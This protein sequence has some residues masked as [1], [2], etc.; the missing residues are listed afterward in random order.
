MM[1]E[2]SGDLVVVG[3]IRR[4]HGVKGV[5]VVEPT[6][7]SAHLVFV[8]G[9]EFI[10]GTIK[11]EP[12][13]PEKHLRVEMAEPF[14]GGYRVQLDA[15]T[16]R[17]EADRW[18]KRCLL[19]PRAGLPEPGE[20]EIYLHDLVGLAAMDSMGEVV[21]SVVAYYELKHDVMIEISRGDSTV[22]IPYRFVTEVDLEARRLVVEPPEGLL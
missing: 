2:E 11:G 4:S 15:I 21:G 3:R 10:A 5:V 7:A 18:Q 6:T 9:R 17:D 22:M 20:N 14:Q 1:L 12:S 8:E 16:D 13:S 19:A